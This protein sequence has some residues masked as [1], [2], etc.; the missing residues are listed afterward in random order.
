MSVCTCDKEMTV[1]LIDMAAIAQSKESP[2]FTVKRQQMNIW[3]ESIRRCFSLCVSDLRKCEGIVL[4]R[5]RWHSVGHWNRPFLLEPVSLPAHVR[6]K[7]LPL[8]SEGKLISFF[9]LSYSFRFLWL[10]TY[11]QKRCRWSSLKE[12]AKLFQ[13]WIFSYSSPFLLLHT[14]MQCALKEF[15]WERWSHG[16]F[17]F[18]YSIW[19]FILWM[20]IWCQEQ[21]PF[22]IIPF[23]RHFSYMYPTIE[24]FN[25]NRC[26]LSHDARRNIFHKKK[27]VKLL[28][29]QNL[30]MVAV[31]SGACI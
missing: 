25:W 2:C 30:Q 19:Q 22:G 13:S 27:F 5:I 21:T 16:I 23:R 8:G 17:I 10:H 26:R 24:M 15:M 29:S 12:K 28:L 6:A 1:H 3:N 20:A 14:P 4:P 18:C 11:R 7:K 9:D 31:A